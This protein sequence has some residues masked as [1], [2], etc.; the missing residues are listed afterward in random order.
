MQA[1]LEIGGYDDILTVMAR[2]AIVLSLP[3]GRVC[4]ENG[5]EKE[6]VTDPCCAG[7]GLLAAWKITGD[8]QF[9]RAYDK[10]LHYALE[11]APRNE[12][13]VVYHV[14]R[15]PEFWL[16]SMYML[17][18]FLADA[19]KYNEA[20]CQVNGYWEALYD[21][22]WQLMRWI[23]DDGSKKIKRANY[24]SICNG[25]AVAGMTR[26]LLALPDTMAE[27]KIAMLQKIRLLIDG[28]LR[29]TGEDG[30]SRDMYDD[31][32]TH[33]AMNG[34]LILTGVLYRLLAKKLIPADPYLAVADRLRAAFHSRVDA[35]GF[36]MDC[37][38]R[39]PYT[40]ASSNGQS[41]FLIME[42]AHRDYEE[43]LREEEIR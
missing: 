10:L 14:T 5:D 33:V 11:E 3:D 2:Q 1:L 31:P 29:V 12:Q 38:R 7:N 18:P 21:P 6:L 19:G 30:F 16:D 41:F 17:P 13:G 42:A 8:E 34:A 36:V 40:R 25:F 32:T 39:E 24:R 4:I 22:E 43:Q 37:A 26:V 23:W 9:K 20:V 28:M 15:A 27:E 35:Y